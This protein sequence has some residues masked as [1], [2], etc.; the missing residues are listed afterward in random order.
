VSEDER[1][2]ALHEAMGDYRVH[3]R[4]LDEL[5]HLAWREA[6]R[7]GSTVISPDE[8]V[9]AILH[10]K[11]GDSVA[12]QA[13]RACGVDREALEALTGRQRDEEEI[14]DGPQY[15][16][17][18]Y[19]LTALAEGIAAGLGASEVS[20][21]HVLL[22]YLWAP[23][24]SASVL[25]H[26]GTTREEVRA[27]LAAR[28]VDGP[29]GTLPASDPRRYGPCVDVPLDD[30]WILLRQLDF[31]LPLGAS[32]AWNHDGTKGRV[33]VTE[34][35]DADLYVQRALERHRSSFLP[36]EDME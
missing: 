13:L 32:F 15:N 22:A 4:P 31:V 24:H 33:S 16:P 19:K 2:R 12:A 18:G 26:L 28:G 25:E 14:S 3:L 10:P 30:L 9:L 20:A 11:A 29:Q 6:R 17:A 21:E 5:G 23:E 27:A 36:A 7:L 8:Y 35:L 34:G 1:I